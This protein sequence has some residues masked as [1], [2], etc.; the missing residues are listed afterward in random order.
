MSC[1]LFFPFGLFSL[2]DCGR[3]WP[4]EPSAEH[5][6][7]VTRPS[8][9]GAQ[10]YRG[11]LT[12]DSTLLFPRQFPDR[13]E[14]AGFLDQRIDSAEVDRVTAELQRILQRQ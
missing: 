8:V 1:V 3:C 7:C 6:E 14:G 12:P 2:S 4:G 13:I 5:F 9:F 11:S 10:I